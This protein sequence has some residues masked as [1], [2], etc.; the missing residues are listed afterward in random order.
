MTYNYL[1]NPYELYITFIG[2][3]EMTENQLIL[4]HFPCRIGPPGG[5]DLTKP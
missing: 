4:D 5:V 3:L 2:Q 1:T